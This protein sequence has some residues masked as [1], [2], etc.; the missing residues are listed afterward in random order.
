MWTAFITKQE[1]YMEN[2]HKIVFQSTAVGQIL[3]IIMFLL[4]EL[5]SYG[6]CW[7]TYK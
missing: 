7:M 3:L 4:C 5:F 1:K 2:V 6:F